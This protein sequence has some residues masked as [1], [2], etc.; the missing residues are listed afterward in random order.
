MTILATRALPRD[1]LEGRA[2]LTAVRA[3]FGQNMGLPSSPSLDS[4]VSVAGLTLQMPRCAS[5]RTVE[6][7]KYGGIGHVTHSHGPLFLRRFVALG[8]ST[9]LSST[10]TTMPVSL[11]YFVLIS[12][13]HDV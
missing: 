11:S 5:S 2:A 9:S 3:G 7:G 13:L 1:A 6:A 10:P 12:Y 4:D 8:F